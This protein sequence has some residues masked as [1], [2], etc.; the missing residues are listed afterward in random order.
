M[1]AL[2]P[3]LLVLA[4]VALAASATRATLVPSAAAVQVSRTGVADV[5]ALEREASQDILFSLTPAIG[6]AAAMRLSVL[7]PERLDTSV[8][9]SAGAPSAQ[10]VVADVELSG[11]AWR[12]TGR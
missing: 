3:A 4:C 8:S 12:L 10:I 6:D 2:P 7:A 11:F 1:R 5:L 9:R